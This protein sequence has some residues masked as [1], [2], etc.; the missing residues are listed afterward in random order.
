[1][2]VGAAL[3]IFFGGIFAGVVNAMAGGGSL[4]TVPLLSLAGVEGLS[5]NGTNRIAVL[6]QGCT[7]TTGG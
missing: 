5:A 6:I 2:S 3:L 4:L 7:T 1:M